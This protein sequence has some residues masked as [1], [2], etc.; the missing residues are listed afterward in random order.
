MTDCITFT[1]PEVIQLE[2][3]LKL[4]IKRNDWLFVDTC[5]EAA[6]PCGLF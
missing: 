3:I 2:F 4:K 5:S 6:N 1:G